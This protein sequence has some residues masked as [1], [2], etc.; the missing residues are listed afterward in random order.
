LNH[1]YYLSS[2]AA[3]CELFTTSSSRVSLTLHSFF[4][5]FQQPASPS[6]PLLAHLRFAASSSIPFSK[7]E[8]K[9][10]KRKGKERSGVEWSGVSDFVRR[11]VSELQRGFDCACRQAGRQAGRAAFVRTISLPNP[12]RKAWTRL[13]SELLTT[14]SPAYIAFI[15]HLRVLN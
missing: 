8:R 6:L 10:N 1:L 13:R 11:D 4:P 15:I 2:C 5:S 9:G 12:K 3:H 14:G 7:H